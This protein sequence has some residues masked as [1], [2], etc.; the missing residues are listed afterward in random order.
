MKKIISN[1]AVLFLLISPV[2]A[3]AQVHDIPQIFSGKKGYI[4]NI[5]YERKELLVNFI[6][7]KEKEIS[8][9]LILIIDKTQFLDGNKMPLTFKDVKSND[10]II[11]DGQYYKEDR[12]SEATTITIVDRKIKNIKEGLIDYINEDYAFIDGNKVKL[13][14]GVLIK[15]QKKT[16]YSDKSFTSLNQLKEGD[17]ATA[18]GKY[19]TK[20]FYLIDEMT[21]APNND[22]QFD[23]IA[24]TIDTKEYNTFIQLWPDKNKRSKFF[25]AEIKGIGKIYND[26]VVQD[27][28]QNLGT[29]LVPR[30][31]KNKKKFVF[32]V[33]ENTI[34]NANIRPNGLAYIYTGLLKSVENE[35]Q[36]A[37]VI[38]HE[39]AHVIYEHV[40]K[41][42]KKE[43]KG[44]ST[45]G[46]FD[47]GHKLLFDNYKDLTALSNSIIDS[48]L[49]SYTS[50]QE[51]QADRVGLSFMMMAG[52]DP[53][54]SPLFW[55]NNYNFYGKTEI[56]TQAVTFT[57]FAVNKLTE[58][59]KPKS[60]K[61][62]ASE[63]PDL[64]ADLIKW[65]TNN[66]REESRKTYPEDLER[67]ETLNQ[68]ISLYW[69]DNEQLKKATKGA[70]SYKEILN[71]L[72]G[73]V[74]K[75][76]K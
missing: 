19:D 3:L 36:L 8:K 39:I 71:R 34:Q 21:S 57:K 55:K 12:Y 66:Y 7:D 69:N 11:L 41:V 1:L 28:V 54:E 5:D 65:K 48:R 15:G 53:R 56:P 10:Q 58:E 17:Y 47:T 45:K 27:Y 4:Q 72:N 35:A 44:K 73:K 59:E 76:K 61:K 23:K 31:M 74:A 22:S 38:S 68:H 42:S 67:F 49:S 32:I 2:I 20:G 46:I 70:D 50:D 25:G 43:K 6:L 18:Y 24:D 26:A 51:L 9:E 63:E 29:K 64:T 37:A 16:G 62:G 75:K 60:N 14:A 40:A 30:S 52:Y 13:N 33:V